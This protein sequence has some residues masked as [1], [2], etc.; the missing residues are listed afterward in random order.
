MATEAFSAAMYS[1]PRVT[2]LTLRHMSALRAN[3]RGREAATV[4]KEQCLI[5]AGDMR[6]DRSNQWRAQPVI[7]RVFMQ[8]DQTHEWWHSAPS[9]RLQRQVQVSTLIRATQTLK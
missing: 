6:I 8:I 5:A 9:P 1:H 7:D 4:D 3:Q 2:A